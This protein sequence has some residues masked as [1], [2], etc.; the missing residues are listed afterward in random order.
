[1]KRDSLD[2]LFSTYIRTR[3]RWICQRCGK[4]QAKKSFGY[5][6]C[7]IF[8]RAKQS[9]RF[10]PDNAFG[11]CYGCH[12]WLDTHPDIK[13]EFAKAHLG[14]AKYDALSFRASMPTKIDR[15]MVKV[16]L[17]SLLHS[18]EEERNDH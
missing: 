5:H 17:E 11:A 15:V 13:T 8:S 16:A 10:D 6:S 2:A 4:G 18:L 1:M 9:V 3:D 7:H 12:R 14:Q